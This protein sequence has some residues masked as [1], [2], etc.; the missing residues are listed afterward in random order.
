MTVEAR[1]ND[2][3]QI[4][5]PADVRDHLHL[6]PGQVVEVSVE[7]TDMRIRKP[8]VRTPEEIERFERAVEKYAGSMP[9]DRNQ[10][11]VST[12]DEYMEMIRG[13]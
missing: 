9:F 6:V 10:D 7:G 5:I 11:G 13:R 8:F 12:V 2:Q 3:G 1:I 4:E